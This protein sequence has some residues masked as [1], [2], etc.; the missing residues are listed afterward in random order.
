MEL[1]IAVFILGLSVGMWGYRTYVIHALGRIPT[2]KCDYCQ[3]RT[4][5]EIGLSS[6]KKKRK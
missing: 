3:F 1:I 6:Q 2:T 5:M 4:M